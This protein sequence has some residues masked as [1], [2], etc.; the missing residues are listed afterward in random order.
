MVRDSKLGLT[1]RPLIR[2]ADVAKL[3][4]VDPQVIYR[5]VQAGTIP[6]VRVGGQIRF[7]PA[8]VENYIRKQTTTVWQRGTRGRPKVRGKTNAQKR[9]VAKAKGRKG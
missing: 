3:L 7:R 6:H 4:D 8:D 2:V 1:E 9:K 5:F